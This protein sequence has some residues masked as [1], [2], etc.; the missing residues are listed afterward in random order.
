MNVSRSTKKVGIVMPNQPH[1]NV[2]DL[3]HRLSSQDVP[4][5]QQAQDELRVLIAADVRRIQRIQT[6]IAGDAIAMLSFFTSIL[7]YVLAGHPLEYHPSSDVLAML[8]VVFAGIA[9][10][11]ILLQRRTVRRIIALDIPQA[12]GPLIDVLATQGCVAGGKIKVALIRLLPRLR[13]SDASF[14]TSRHRKSL[15]QFFRLDE[16]WRD[17]NGVHGAA[18]K[19]AVLRALEQIGDETS[20]PAVERLA[21]SAR[22]PQVRAAA[23]DCLPFLQHRIEKARIEQTLLRASGTGYSPEVLLR[24]ANNEAEAA[25]E[26]LLRAS[27][28]NEP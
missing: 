10:L 20:L 2:S 9:W 13:S 26:Q 12:V 11:L 19:I 27:P 14:L 28:V 17:S 6:A 8:I 24:P 18:L 23:Q 3:A 25:P 7:V 1:Q 15:N 21:K 16:S 22:D 5:R 4:T